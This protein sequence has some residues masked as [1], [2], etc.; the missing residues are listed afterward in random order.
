M[1]DEPPCSNGASRVFHAGVGSMWDSEPLSQKPSAAVMWICFAELTGDTNPVHLDLAYARTTSFR[2][3]VVHVCPGQRVDLSTARYPRMPGHGCVLLH[4]D[5]RFPVRK[6]KMAFAFIG[7]EVTVM[8]AE[9]ERRTK[10][11]TKNPSVTS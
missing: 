11:D 2:A 8:M 3:P 9:E 1:N 10:V 6:V 5:I 4:Q 7:G